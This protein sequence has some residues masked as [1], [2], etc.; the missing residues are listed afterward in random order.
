MLY[1]GDLRLQ[2]RQGESR[3]G[4]TWRR[5]FGIQLPGAR[6]DHVPLFLFPKHISGVRHVRLLRHAGAIHVRDRRV[7]IHK[8]LY[9]FA[10]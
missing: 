5:I 4:S 3:L 2:Y 9:S 6:T 8:Y 10:R 7:S 1:S